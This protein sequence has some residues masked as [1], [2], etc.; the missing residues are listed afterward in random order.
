MNKNLHK[1]I[2][3]MGKI[4][5]RDI[6]VYN[7]SFL[8][9]SLERRLIAT[10]FNNGYEYCDFLE[11]NN[12]EA[13]AFYN[14]LQISFSQFFR[15][16][17]TFV[18]LEQ[19]IV[20][21]LIFNKPAGSEIRIWSA[22]CSSGQE[23]YSIAMML[24]DFTDSKGKE[25]NFRIFATDISQD[26]LALGHAGVYDQNSVKNVKKKYLDKYFT[27]QGENYSIVH[28]LKK[29][30]NFSTYDLLDLSTANP[31]ESIYGDFDI[32][33]CS[34][35]LIYYKN[36]LQQAIIKK[37]QKAISATGYLVTGEVERTLVQNTALLQMISTPT[38]VFKNNK[39]RF[40]Q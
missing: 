35:L 29:N 24:S 27:K 28:K 38:A 26:A 12:A 20:P 25:I 22:G 13:D 31:P 1:I 3:V 36:D 4:Y 8:L 7:Q 6:S 14:S 32:V 30:I 9:K 33:M 40:I 18:L 19:L 21:D 15:D 2:T 17:L 5:G 16:S 11:K 39:G 34:N 10:G 37:L 23:A